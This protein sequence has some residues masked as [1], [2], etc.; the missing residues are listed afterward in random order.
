MDY[1][2]TA[3]NEQFTLITGKNCGQC[4]SLKRF[5]EASK[6]DYHLVSDEANANEFVQVSEHFNICSI[7]T[8]VTKDLKVI[9]GLSDCI[10]YC[11]ELVKQS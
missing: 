8:I 7:P 2:L 1:D 5:L 3:I 4:E 9:T 6:I 11:R 10:G